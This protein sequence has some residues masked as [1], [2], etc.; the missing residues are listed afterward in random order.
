MRSVE[1]AGWK[2]SIGLD[3]YL[4]AC[5]ADT[6]DEFGHCAMIR[7]ILPEEVDYNV[8]EKWFR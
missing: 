5:D 8:F 3:I 1:L 7:Q 6:D 2:V 4:L